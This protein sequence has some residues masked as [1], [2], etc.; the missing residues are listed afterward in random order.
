MPD[1][2][3]FATAQGTIAKK[4]LSN[5]QKASV[6]GI[7]SLGIFLRVEPRWVIFLSFETYKGPLTLNL[8][9]DVSSLS[10]LD[11]KNPIEVRNGNIF[12]IAS[13]ITINSNNAE[14]WDIPSRSNSV[15]S[16]P[17]R[18]H[19]IKAVASEMLA[20]RKNVGLSGSLASLLEI[21]NT[22]TLSSS[23]P[24]NKVNIRELQRF[25]HLPDLSNILPALQPLLGLGT[26]LTPSGDDL[27]IGLL[28][29]Y[30]RWGDVINPMFDLSKLNEFITRM[31]YHETTLISASL[32]ACA[33]QGYADERLVK[34]LDGMM[35]GSP[36]APACAESLLNWGGS[37]GIDALVGM[38]LAAY[39]N[40]AL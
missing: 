31:A 27:I 1:I 7:T 18:N 6:I 11:Q 37:S 14:I 33:A 34:A 3:L 16:L 5:A 30:N 4:V 32:I 29:A 35:T 12:F 23:I 10:H 19:R 20:K 39:E 38:V 40:L 13:G 9:G 28:L 26:G 36:D 22:N 21:G 25:I 2:E 24:F 8:E 17:E 15:L